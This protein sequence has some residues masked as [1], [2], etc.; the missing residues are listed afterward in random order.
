VPIIPRTVIPST[1]HTPKTP[2]TPYNDLPPSG[3]VINALPRVSS[4]SPKQHLHR[5][6]TFTEDFAASVL[7][8][9][10]AVYS[11]L[12]VEE[13]TRLAPH[14]WNKFLNDREHKPFASAS[15]IFILC[16]EKSPETVKDLIMK[17]LYR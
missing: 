9:L 11:T 7:S 1:P 14:I 4:K 3:L 5:F 17:D 15:F 6:N 13:F 8:L 12:T 10:V 2:V 16:G